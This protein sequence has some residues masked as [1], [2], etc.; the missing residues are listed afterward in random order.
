[1]K[2]HLFLT[3][4]L[5]GLSG[6]PAALAQTQTAPAP[7]QMGSPQ[8]TDAQVAVNQDN[9]AAWDAPEQSIGPNHRTTFRNTKAG[10]HLIEEIGTGMNYWDGTQWSPSVPK[11]V[12]MNGGYAARQVQHQVQL[13]GNLFGDGAVSVQT[14]DGI[15][16]NSTPLAIALYDSA[17]GNFQVISTVTNCAPT[18]VSSNE[19]MYIDAFSGGVC[20]SVV[21]TI[22]AGMFHQ[23][24][25]ITGH[26]DP[27]DY[28][29]PTNTTQ[30]QI[31]T[32]FYN[33]P[34]PDMIRRPIYVE[35]DQKVRAKMVSPDLVDE[36]LGFGQFVLTTGKAYTAPNAANAGGNEAPVAK[37][38]KTIAGRTYLFESVPF[39][40][41]AN[42]L[43]AL[44][45]CGNGASSVNSTGVHGYAGIPHPSGHLAKAAPF[46]VAS[47]FNPPGVVIDYVAN[48]GGT[49]SGTTVFKGDTTYLVSSA[50][51]CNGATTIEG[52]AVFKYKSGMSIT[53]NSTLTCKTGM[54]HPA[55][56]TGVDDNSV[57]DTMNGVTGSGYTGTISSSGYANPALASSGALTFSGLRFRYAQEAIKMTD[58]SSTF[59]TVLHSQFINC[60]KGIELVGNWSGCGCGCGCGCGYVTSYLNLYNC[61]VSAVQYPLYNS[62]T[63]CAPGCGPP[64][65]Q[66]ISLLNCTFDQGTKLDYNS[67]YSLAVS[68]NATNSVFAN[69]SALTNSPLNTGSSIVFAGGYNGFYSAATFGSS[70]ATAGSSPFQ[71]VGAGGHYLTSA[72]GFRDYGSGT[73]PTSLAADLKLRTTY[74]PPSVTAN[75]T[76]TTSQAWGPQV[77]RDADTPDLGYHYDPVDYAFGGVYVTN[78]AITLSNGVVVAT[79]G[80]NNNT[81]YGLGFGS[82]AS[83]SS[84]GTPNCP[85]WF[86]AYNTV[87][88]NVG[89]NGNW[90]TPTN[91]ITG[92]LYN[93]TPAPA[94]YARFTSWSVLAQDLPQFY[95]PTNTGSIAFQ[96]CEFHDGKIV[97]YR[98]TIN[99]TNCLLERAYVSL[100]STDGNSPYIRNNLFFGGT[101]NF[102]PNVSSALVKDNFFD[103]TAIPDNSSVYTTYDGGYNGFVTGYDRLQPTFGSDK[104]LTASPAYKAGPLGSYYQATN[105][106][107]IDAG[108]TTADQ[109]G[110]YFYT[111]QTNQAVETVST[112]DIG[113][114]YM[115]LDAT[116]IPLVDS[117]SDGMDDAWEMLYF[118]TLSIDPN[119]DPDGDGLTNLQEY[120]AGTN[121]N[122]DDSTITGS[123]LNYIYDA[124]GWLQQV[125]GAHIGTISLDNEGNTEHVSQ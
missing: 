71:T 44:P 69:L 75:T 4:L 39:M 16:L 30:I 107:L 13:A 38:Y 77:Q 104:I 57:G 1:M 110:L 82:G 24:V 15:T 102:T 49:L 40:A 108:S 61:L 18:Q 103:Q 11:F 17:S 37:E 6:L 31:V 22:T 26:L 115:A 29:F 78:A 117:N 106:P 81:V 113:Y 59:W 48:I 67:G 41:L 95:A 35:P 124:G 5:A 93:A 120:Q 101:F 90:Q 122:V 65:H 123:R 111:T 114:H 45:D 9:Y 63:G 54:Y 12:G 33:A 32:E 97:T 62:T 84:I 3:A 47:N 89:T 109:L 74:P 10:R 8:L 92:E 125:S 79:F 98:P 112:V 119:A 86:V 70:P 85:N 27:A 52:G 36:T 87:M 21:Y 73:L 51:Y 83:L 19:V 20:A 105:S 23:D 46:K 68:L 118:G 56:F 25:M 94:I 53:L 64:M 28:G 72:S 42:D 100:A 7:A 14:P 80:T 50:V 91:S 116:G 55:V 99:L 34:T 60:V 76:L 121:P 88:E 2:K 66:Y 96:D 43:L 58:S